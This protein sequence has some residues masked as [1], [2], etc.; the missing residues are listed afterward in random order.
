MTEVYGY[1]FYNPPKLNYPYLDDK[2]VK[3]VFEKRATD[4]W[5]DIAKKFNSNVVIA[6]KNWNLNL[7]SYFKGKNYNLYRIN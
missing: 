2:F 4:E 1:D 5:N 3:K 6:P 7:K